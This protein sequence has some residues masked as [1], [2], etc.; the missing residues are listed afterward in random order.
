M[1]KGRRDIDL[2]HDNR[3]SRDE[4]RRWWRGRA[5]DREFAATPHERTYLD[6]WDLDHDS[7]YDDD[8]VANGLVDAFDTNRDDRIDRDEWQAANRDVDWAGL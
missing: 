6:A 3:L 7:R 4:M 1:Q 2:D 8:E 5:G